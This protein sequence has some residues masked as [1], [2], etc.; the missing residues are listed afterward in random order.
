M[1][2]TQ[3]LEKRMCPL[4]KV[5]GSSRMGFYPL[6]AMIVLMQLGYRKARVVF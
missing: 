1:S 2:D 4:N 6:V 5:V 3:D